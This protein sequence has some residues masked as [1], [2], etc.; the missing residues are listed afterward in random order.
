MNYEPNLGLYDMRRDTEGLPKSLANKINS[1]ICCGGGGGTTTQVTKSGMNE[2]FVPIYREAMQ[3]ALTGYKGRK[4]TGV[5]ATVADLAPEQVE[6]LAYQ[7]QAARDQIRGRGAYDMNEANRS[8]LKNTMGDM[9]GTASSGGVLGSARS[10]K[11]MASAITDQSM[12]QQRARQADITAGI[13]ALGQAGTTR[14]Q[15]QQQRI[16]APYTEQAR[17]SGLLAGAPQ[18]STQTSSGGGK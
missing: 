4:E 1:T 12:Q 5:S 18:S 13:G 11:A 10:Q 6:A 3:D 7:T 14:Q 16:D 15:F 8:A 17:L 2:E 9:M